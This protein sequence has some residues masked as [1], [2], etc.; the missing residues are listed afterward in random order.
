MRVEWDGMGWDVMG[1]DGMR[2]DA[3][4]WDGTGRNGMGWDGMRRDRI[5]S[6][7]MGCSGMGTVHFHL[8]ATLLCTCQS[9]R[10]VG[11]VEGMASELKVEVSVEALVA[12]QEVV[13]LAVAFVVEQWDLAVEA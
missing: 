3:M 2:S 12:L 13:R 7:R 6:D 8:F 10:M 4:R 11:K 1:W 5:G 9:S